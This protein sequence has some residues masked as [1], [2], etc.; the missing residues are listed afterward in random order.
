MNSKTTRPVDAT[1]DYFKFKSLERMESEE[2]LEGDEEVKLEPEETIP[3]IVKLNSRKNK[4]RELKI[5]TRRK[6]LT[7]IPIY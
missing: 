5:L 3:E 1:I 7:R 6:L 2:S 4:G